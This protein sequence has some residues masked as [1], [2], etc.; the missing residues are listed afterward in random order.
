MGNIEC[1]QTEIDVLTLGIEEPTSK[2]I[3]MLFNE[4]FGDCMV[5]ESANV[6][7]IEDDVCDI[8]SLNQPYESINDSDSD[9]NVFWQDLFA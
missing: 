1:I 6:E 9:D 5:G 7:I 4:V 3:S 2:F 8:L